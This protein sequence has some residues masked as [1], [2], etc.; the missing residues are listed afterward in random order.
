MY[1]EGSLMYFGCLQYSCKYSEN[2]LALSMNTLKL[3]WRNI[4]NIPQEPQ[5]IA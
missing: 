5:P 1:N 4:S 3:L 2:F